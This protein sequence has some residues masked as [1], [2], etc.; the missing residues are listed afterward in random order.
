MVDDVAKSREKE[1]CQDG[2]G[3]I[4]NL[5]RETNSPCLCIL[6]ISPWIYVL[7]KFMKQFVYWFS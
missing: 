7:R 2:L 3:E 5:L 1:M 6:L 4:Y